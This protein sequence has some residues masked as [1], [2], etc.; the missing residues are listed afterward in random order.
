M[1]K[2]VFDKFYGLE[3]FLDSFFKG[4]VRLL[5]LIVLDLFPWKLCYEKNLCK[6]MKIKGNQRK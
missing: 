6:E 1:S 4:K 3:E 5:H 2:V